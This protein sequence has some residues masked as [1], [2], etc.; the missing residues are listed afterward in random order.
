LSDQKSQ[1]AV[2]RQ[3][4]SETDAI[5]EGP[6]PRMARATVWTLSALIASLIAVMSLTKMDRVVSSPGKI[7]PEQ[8]LNVYQALDPSII[9]SISVREGQE[10]EKGQ[11]LASLDP[12]FAAADVK[13]L[14]IQIIGLDAQ[15]A[16]DEALL[17]GT[18]L[19]AVKNDNPDIRR[20][21]ALN[22]SY[23]EQQLAQYNAQ[24][25]SFDA[26]IRQT[27][28]TIQKY[29]TD[30]NEYQRR[31]E[32]AKQIED[33]RTVL[34]AHGSGSELNKLISQDQHIDL[35]RNLEYD[36]NSL[37][38]AQHT[39]ASLNSDKQ[40]FI[41]QWQTSISQDLVSARSALDSAKSQLEKAVKHADLV[42]WTAS[43]KS[44]VLTV[45]KLSVG[46]VLKEGDELFTLMPVDTPLEAEAHVSS[47]DIGFLRT[48]D[49][50]R[51]KVE[52]FNYMEHGT[53]D[54][55]VRW[56]SEGAFSTNEDTGQVAE[57]YYKVRCSID[58]MHFANVG[59]KFRLLP[60]MT[61]TADMNV[62]SRSVLAYLMN[63]VLRG[64]D[65]A[66]REP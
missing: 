56:I 13:Q 50:C 51:L 16:R 15:I 28:A 55:T 66:M 29:Q 19:A 44:I 10:V 20:Y 23:Y 34:A 11:E 40:A 63:G 38:E 57:P 42:R 45:A 7:V 6:E 49:H 39:L 58:E 3:F 5:R 54:G 30:Q 12:T 37:T 17:A 22:Q 32:I 61:L 43:G 46:S 21:A 31:S 59:P 41:Q 48:G 53:A 8:R 14:Q 1:L 26:K 2:V 36:S 35:I 52:A 62:G 60:G 24:L 47:R 9:R 33:M 18:P 27:Q 64:F 65:E 4:H 25:D